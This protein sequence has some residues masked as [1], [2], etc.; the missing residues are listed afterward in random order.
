MHTAIQ[1]QH[2]ANSLL[3]FQKEE[4]DHLLHRGFLDDAEHGRVTKC[5]DHALN[6]LFHS[7]YTDL[8][9]ENPD[10]QSMLLQS[11]LFSALSMNEL[12][13]V[14][15]QAKTSD[16]Y[17][18]GDVIMKEGTETR[19]L[20][21][22][23]HGAVA[24][25]ST[26]QKKKELVHTKERGEVLDIWS[27]LHNEEHTFRFEV[28][29]K[30]CNGYWLEEDLLANLKD[31]SV[32]FWDTLW[33]CAASDAIRLYFK[34][35]NIMRGVEMTNLDAEVFRSRLSYADPSSNYSREIRITRGL[36]VLLNG[37]VVHMSD[38][39]SKGYVQMCQHA[40]VFSGKC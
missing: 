5:C 17:N 22:I 37:Q 23:T 40:G 27:F 36:G 14:R 7:S 34:N 13:A 15:N 12:D 11:P 19:K 30:N 10:S 24:V 25:H 39:S 2:A 20:F 26:M 32:E 4:I 18:K 9:D 21:V 8:L 28:K 1:T 38:L 16:W 3:N 31:E 35:E 29:S 6:E 33:K